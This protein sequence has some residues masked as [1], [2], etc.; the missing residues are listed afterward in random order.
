VTEG[1]VAIAQVAVGT[2][3]EGDGMARVDEAVAHV[4]EAEF[5]AA[6]LGGWVFFEGDDVHALALWEDKRR[7]IFLRC[8]TPGL[9]RMPVGSKNL[10]MGDQSHRLTRFVG[11]IQAFSR[12]V[13]FE[14]LIESRFA[15]F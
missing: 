12:I 9:F 4:K 7:K 2:M 15:S 14:T 3:E 11:S 8:T 5:L 1:G 10:Q 13:F 6:A